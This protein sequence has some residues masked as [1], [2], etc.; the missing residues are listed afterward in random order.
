MPCGICRETGHNARTCS[1]LAPYSRGELNQYSRGER[2]PP[3]HYYDANDDAEFVEFLNAL[4]PEMDS[5]AFI[6]S[7]KDEVA[8]ELEE[9]MVCYERVTNEKV[10][11]ECGHSY[12]VGCFVK[13]MRVSNTCAYC[14]AEVCEP[15]PSSK[16]HMSTD[17]RHALVQQSLDGLADAMYR[18]FVEQMRASFAVQMSRN[19]SQLN[20]RSRTMM[21]EMT[22]RAASSV[23]MTFASWV[24]G[25]QTSNHMS[26]WYES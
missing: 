26:D 5:D 9:C 10:S 19:E 24:V 21:N 20:L 22:V 2:E 12:C 15:P 4:E 8:L 11:L 3:P 16:K 14:R 23:D 6:Q 1:T 13:H 17:T 25:L 18:D 7:L